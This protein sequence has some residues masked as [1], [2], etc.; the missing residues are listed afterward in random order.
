MEKSDQKSAESPP[1]GAWRPPPSSAAPPGVVSRAQLNFFAA[2]GPWWPRE[3]R[4]SAGDGQKVRYVEFKP[5]NLQ[6]L[7]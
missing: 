7:I 3:R 2:R 6:L 4:P 1:S 5:P